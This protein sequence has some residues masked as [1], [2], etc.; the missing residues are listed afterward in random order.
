MAGPVIA[1]YGGGDSAENVLRLAARM[2]EV[3][4]QPL[5][6]LATADT[7]TAAEKLA[8]RAREWLETR[9]IVADM[10]AAAANSV[11]LLIE[12]V[13]ACRGRDTGGTLVV[14]ASD[15][16]MQDKGSIAALERLEGAVLL[17]RK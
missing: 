10:R 3:Q 15:G 12:L 8:E 13:R 1:I 16:L 4:A 2:A 14:D 9:H 11:D 17:V 5:I 6:V 7:P